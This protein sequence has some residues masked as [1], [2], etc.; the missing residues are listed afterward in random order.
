MAVKTIDEIMASVKA[1]IGEDT[2]DEAL[3]FVEDISD[4]LNDIASNNKDNIDWK[5]KYEENDKTWREKYRQRFFDGEPKDDPKKKPEEEV[6]GDDK[7]K[8][9]EELFKEEK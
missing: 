5:A 6:T 8:T 2:S 3:A 7:P 1:R 9:F 4:T